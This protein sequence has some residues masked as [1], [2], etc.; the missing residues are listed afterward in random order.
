MT[1]SRMSGNMSHRLCWLYPIVY[2]C[3]AS[4][5]SYLDI[6]SIIVCLPIFIYSVAVLPPAAASLTGKPKPFAATNGLRL[7]SALWNLFAAETF[8]DTCTSCDTLTLILSRY[9]PYHS[10]SPSCH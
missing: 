7:G 5:G 3:N 8:V 4:P 9:L 6:V 1:T 10:S 2:P